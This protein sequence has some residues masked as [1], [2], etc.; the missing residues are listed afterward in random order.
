MQLSAKPCVITLVLAAGDSIRFGADKRQTKIGRDGLLHLTVKKYLDCCEHIVVALKKS[1]QNKLIQLLPQGLKLR[2]QN[3]L[4]Y[5]F[6]R[7]ASHGMGVSLAEG[8]TYIK[9]HFSA[10]AILI[11]LGDMPGVKNCTIKQLIGT[12]I[13]PDSIIGPVIINQQR[14]GHPVLFGRNLIHALQALHGDIGARHII[15]KNKDEVIRIEVDDIG[16]YADIDTPQDILDHKTHAKKWT[17]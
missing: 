1:D 10:D 17:L 2:E 6:V 14:I 7:N 11:A 13:K 3:R 16:I 15:K 12:D 4:H 5:Y 9:Q 8:V